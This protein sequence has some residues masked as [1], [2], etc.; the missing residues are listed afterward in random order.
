[1][2][3]AAKVPGGL[4]QFLPVGVVPPVLVHVGLDL[5]GPV[6]VDDE[7]DGGF[8]HVVCVGQGLVTSG[9]L[10]IELADFLLLLLGQLPPPVL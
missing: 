8:T 6:R 1:M 2:L 7:A 5:G 10:G 4:G 9:S 3:V